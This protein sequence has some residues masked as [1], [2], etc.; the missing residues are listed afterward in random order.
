MKSIGVC[1]SSNTPAER[2]YELDNKPSQLGD[3]LR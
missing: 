3:N 1:Q 2:L